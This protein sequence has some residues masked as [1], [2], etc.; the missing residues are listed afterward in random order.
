MTYFDRF[1]ICEAYYL[2]LS[3]CHGGQ[4]SREYARLCCMADYFRPRPTLSVD[5]LS[6]NAREIYE[7]ACARMLG[8][9]A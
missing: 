8:G 5:T 3:H 9:A 4:W 6:D 1:D 7:R 2:A